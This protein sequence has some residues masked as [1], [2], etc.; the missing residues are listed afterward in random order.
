M[1][2]VHYGALA[3]VAQPTYTLAPLSRRRKSTGRRIPEGDR[4]SFKCTAYVTL[5]GQECT[6]TLE[7]L[8][9]LRIFV[10]RLPPPCPRPH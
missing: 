1:T 3:L 5:C 2:L 9:Q 6:L 8:N 4:A 10:K 7:L